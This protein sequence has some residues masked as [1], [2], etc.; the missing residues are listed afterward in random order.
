MIGARDGLL[1]RRCV[2]APELCRRSFV[3]L[4]RCCPAPAAR[5]SARSQ[6]ASRGGSPS[7]RQI[8]RRQ[9]GAARS[10]SAHLRRSRRPDHEQAPVSRDGSAIVAD[11]DCRRLRR[12]QQPGMVHER[13]GERTGRPSAETGAA[14][15][16]GHEHARKLGSA[17]PIRETVLGVGVASTA[18]V[19][20]GPV[21]PGQRVELVPEGVVTAADEPC[22]CH[23]VPHVVRHRREPASAAQPDGVGLQAR[24]DEADA[25]REQVVCHVSD[26]SHVWLCR[27]P[28]S[29]TGANGTRHRPPPGTETAT[30]PPAGARAVR[31]RA[32][33]GRGRARRSDGPDLVDG[34]AGG[35]GDRP[36]Q[37]PLPRE[38]RAGVAQPMVTT[39]S[40]ACTASAVSFSGNSWA[41]SIPSSAMTARTA[42]SIAAAGA[43]PAEVTRTRP[44]VALVRTAP[45][46][47]P[48]VCASVWVAMS[49]GDGRRGVGRAAMPPR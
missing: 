24:L 27:P 6:D 37:V 32:C 5:S 38:D 36:V 48:T 3:R 8:E 39:T 1:S 44:N 34:A 15:S 35:V 18:E 14:T 42:G 29:G 33:G 9:L 10:E 45:G 21:P 41:R 43:E 30:G 7:G 26:R 17:R 20:P 16:P 40:A 49:R 31:W 4:L 2:R 13:I 28:I 12:D 19:C 47:A 46:M 23:V 11:D 25:L 22:R